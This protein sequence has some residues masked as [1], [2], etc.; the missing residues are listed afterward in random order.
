M[1]QSMYE[2]SVGVKHLREVLQTSSVHPVVNTSYCYN[3]DAV[4]SCTHIMA[5]IGVY[6]QDIIY[7]FL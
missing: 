5:N 7:T 6:V 1:S 2:V 4:S 3:C